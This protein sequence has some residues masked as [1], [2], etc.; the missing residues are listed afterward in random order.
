MAELTDW[1]IFR[2]ASQALIS[3]QNPYSIGS[4]EMQFYNP[5]WFLLPILPLTLLPSIIGL[6]ANAGVSMFALLFITKRLG[7]GVWETFLVL[8]CP[9]HLQS[10]IYGNPEWVPLL[11][12]LLPP[13]LAL[14]LFV[15]KPQATLGLIILL[16]LQEWKRGRY[17]ALLTTLAPTLVLTAAT[18]LLWGAPPIPGPLNPGPRSLF[19]FSLL[20]GLPALVIALRR[21]DKRMA[22]FVGP[23]VSPYVT[24]HGY[25]PALIAFRGK[26]MALAVAISF[27]P[28]LLGIVA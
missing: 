25:L 12:I 7:M 10:L 26:W 20:L 18:V 28:V 9:M 13:P 16:L 11:G 15:T 6:L 24:F 3:G 14:L 17:R 5:A 22:A 21:E 23:F 2:M 27:I 8:V 19:P 4:G 1:D